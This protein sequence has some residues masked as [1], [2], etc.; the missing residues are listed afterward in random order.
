MASMSRK[1][2]NIGGVRAAKALL[3]HFAMAPIKEPAL[4]RCNIPRS[5]IRRSGS[6]AAKRP[7]LRRFVTEPT[8]ISE[9]AGLY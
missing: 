7:G 9:A 8:V 1:T 5:V 6:V 3:S 4:P 2:R